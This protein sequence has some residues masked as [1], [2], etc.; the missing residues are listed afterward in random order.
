MIITASINNRFTVDS[1]SITRPNNTKSTVI[2]LTVYFAMIKSRSR[3][4]V[5]SSANDD[6]RRIETHF[7]ILAPSLDHT[8]INNDNR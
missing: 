3:I 7:G 5:K 4:P 2:N 8:M 1:S 6:S